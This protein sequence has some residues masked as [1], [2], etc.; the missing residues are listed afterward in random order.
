KKT[1]YRQNQF[2]GAFGGPVR[3]NATFFFGSV[4]SF[5]S[6]QGLAVSGQVPTAAQRAG[7]FSSDRLPV[8]DPLSRTQFPGNI[9][10]DSRISPV[11]KRFLPFWPDPNTDL[12]SPNFINAASGRVNDDQYVFRGDHAFSDK[13]KLFARYSFSNVDT[14][15]PTAMP[16]FAVTA[17]MTVQNAA[18]GSTYIIGPKTFLDFRFGYNRENA[19]NSSEQ[20]GKGHIA[21]FGIPG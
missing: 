4:E 7:N 3:K 5:R 6:R 20:I 1:P 9:I 17:S 18:L 19:V 12:A 11:S 2:G 13:W 8:I 15:T 10:P 21:Q 14:F 16:G